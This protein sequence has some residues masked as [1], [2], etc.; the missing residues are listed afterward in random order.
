MKI[1]RQASTDSPQSE[2]L[3]LFQ[4]R[5]NLAD[6]PAESLPEIPFNLD[7]LSDG[8]LMALY[9]EYV[10]WASYAKSQLVL[11]ELTVQ[12]EEDRLEAISSLKILQSVT[13]ENKTDT[14]TLRKAQRDCD[15]EYLE[16]KFALRKA[17]ATKK[18]TDAIFDRCERSISLLSRELSRRISLQKPASPQRYQP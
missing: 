18:L 1:V 14:V 3:K 7:D 10:A 13:G 9:S 5:F 11:A 6:R 16:Q 2:A 4:K 17:E 12:N 8:N 15:P